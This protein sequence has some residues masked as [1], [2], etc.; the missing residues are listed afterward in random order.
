MVNRTDTML[1]FRIRDFIFLWCIFATVYL[2]L[3]SF[4]ISQRESEW[5]FFFFVVSANRQIIRLHH[6]TGCFFFLMK[7]RHACITSYDVSMYFTRSYADR[8][9]VLNHR[10]NTFLNLTACLVIKLCLRLMR[11]I[12]YTCRIYA[13]IFVSQTLSIARQILKGQGEQSCDLSWSNRSGF[14]RICPQ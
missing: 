9:R 4:W 13:N 3:G 5:W 7:M 6:G 10:H 12:N 8:H 1:W 11:I 14:P 2:V